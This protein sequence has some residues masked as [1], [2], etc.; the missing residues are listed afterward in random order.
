M[1]KL[2]QDPDHGSDHENANTLVDQALQ[3][4]ELQRAVFDQLEDGVYMVDRNRRI[5]Y[6][7]SGAEEITGYLAHEVAGQFCHADL[8]MHCDATG[9]GLCGAGCPLSAV[10]QDGR[11]RESSVFARHRH[12]HR[13]P[14]HLRSRAIFDSDGHVIGAVEVFKQVTTPERTEMRLLQA[15]NC[16]DRLTNVATRQYGEMRLAHALEALR[17]FGIPFGWLAVELDQIDELERRYGHGMIDTALKLVART[18]DANAGPL[19]L[20]THWERG[21]F[22]IEIHSCWREGPAALAERLVDL[23]RSSNL[24]WWGDPVRVS[25]SIGGGTSL[26]ADTREALE[27]RA[28]Q[29]L[30]NCRA[31]GGGRAAVW[32]A[33]GEFSGDDLCLP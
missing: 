1:S 22:R 3:Q 33:C 30:A 31:G 7:N 4:G 15:H 14:V 6:W 16:L 5:V 32:H 21:E 18:L 24:E 11:P 25:I 26:P 20:V 9:K 2:D 23:V 28:A 13:V 29:A 8:M 10:M 19:D 17:A 12:G 27:T